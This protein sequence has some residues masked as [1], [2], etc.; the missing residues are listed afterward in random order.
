MRG[1]RDLGRRA[2]YLF[3]GIRG[4]GPFIFRDPVRRAI[5]FQGGAEQE[6]TFAVLGSREQ[7]PEENILGGWGEFEKGHFSFREQR[8]LRQP[9]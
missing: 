9:L 6:K 2:I 3:S 8:E 1:F 4:E 5:H 7:R